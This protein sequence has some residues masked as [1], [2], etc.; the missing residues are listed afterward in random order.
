M[1]IPDCKNAALVDALLDA[2]RLA[3]QKGTN[4]NEQIELVL[5]E[6]GIFPESRREEVEATKAT[7][8]EWLDG[9]IK[10]GPAR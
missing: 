9:V 8:Q 1:T 6:Y 5:N 7:T 10:K 4:L 3:V 2:F